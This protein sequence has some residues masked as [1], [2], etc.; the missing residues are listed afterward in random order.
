M[1]KKDDT[2]K[3]L[4]FGSSTLNHRR[5]SLTNKNNRFHRLNLV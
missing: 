4:D 1:K 3:D 5:E 2:N